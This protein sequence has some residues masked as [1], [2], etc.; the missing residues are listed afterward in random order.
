VNRE[1]RHRIA[2]LVELEEDELIAA[3]LDALTIWW[4]ENRPPSNAVTAALI[5]SPI[6]NEGE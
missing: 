1:L 6:Y 5:A 4:L 3:E 2:R